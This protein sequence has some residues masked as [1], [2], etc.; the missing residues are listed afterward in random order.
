ML[1]FTDRE[2]E[3]A[4]PR[5]TRLEVTEQ[6]FGESNPGTQGPEIK[7]PFCRGDGSRIPQTR[8]TQGVAIRCSRSLGNG[9]AVC[10][11]VCKREKKKEIF[12]NLWPVSFQIL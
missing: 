6:S 8:L 1:H 12:Y 7:S 10:V 2:S 3:L 5:I 9:D 4:S 11:F